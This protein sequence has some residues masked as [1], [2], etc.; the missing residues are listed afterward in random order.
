MRTGSAEM[1][2]PHDL[3]DTSSPRRW[4]TRAAWDESGALVRVTVVAVG[5]LALCTSLSLRVPV[6]SALAIVTLLPA[7]LVDVI[8]RR[9]PNRMVANAAIVVAI[10]ITIGHVASVSV[11][12]GDVF[13]GMGAMVIPLLAIHL[14]A[15]KAMGF[16]DVKI[17]VVLGAG[18]G[19]VDPSYSL[20]ALL[21]ASAGTAAVG[22]VR[23]LDRLPFGPGL[24][25]GSSLALTIGA[26]ASS[27]DRVSLDQSESG[28]SPLAAHVGECEHADHQP[29]GASAVSRPAKVQRPVGTRVHRRC[30][31]TST[32]GVQ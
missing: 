25:I 12:F 30:R 11:R 29:S 7:F 24:I 3:R 1:S 5:V 13:V 19:L 18:L 6:A 22:L 17:G 9:L 27:G 28:L 21:I 4:T 8:E 26:F 10:A 23:R 32:T 2:S 14:V 15:P 20:I 31:T 16:G